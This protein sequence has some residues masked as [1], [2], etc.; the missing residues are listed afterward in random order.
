M[1]GCCLRVGCSRNSKCAFCQL[2]IFALDVYF[3]LSIRNFMSAA[4]NRPSIRE[5]NT[6]KVGSELHHL[7]QFGR[8]FWVVEDNN[9]HGVYLEVWCNVVFYINV[10]LYIAS[11]YPYFGSTLRSFKVFYREIW[12]YTECYTMSCNIVSC[13]NNG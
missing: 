6:T 2:S 3:R 9:I 5:L 4:Q 7:G 10:F 11:L 8:I 13:D 1:C 12:I